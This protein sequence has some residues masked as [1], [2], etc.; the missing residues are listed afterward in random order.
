MF[1]L[2]SDA[3]SA[4]NQIGLLLMATVFILIGGAIAGY[5][6]YWRIKAQRVRGRVSGVRAKKEQKGSSFYY[7]VFEYQA[8]N[9]EM[10]EHVSS[11]G[12]N[13][14]FGKIPGTQVQ[15]MMM[16]HQPEKVRRPALILALFGLVFLLPGFWIMNVALTRFEFNYMMV[17]M[18][19]IGLGFVGFKVA[20]AVRKIPEGE[21]K[22]GW[23][24]FKEKGV[25]VT[26]SGEGSKGRLLSQDDITQAVKKQV[27]NT[28][29]GGYMC[30]LIALGLGAGSYYA[31]Q[32]MHAMLRDGVP[33]QGEVTGMKRSD[34][35]DSVT[36]SAIVRFTD[37]SGRRVKFT[38]SV[39]SSHPTLKRGDGVDVL[40]LR[41]N[42]ED[43]I[44]DRGVWNWFLS[45]ALGLGALLF[46]WGG[47]HSFALV[48]RHGGTKYRDRV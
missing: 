2:I 14:L 10:M 42:P 16:P 38:D 31:G 46:L 8:P 40:Y 47:M 11:M 4:W 15:L 36:Y 32:S 1:E 17:I 5:E 43:A 26:S 12:S 20:G 24:E 33:A 23:A 35:S 28:R 19:L 44:V 6:L 22:K 25:K 37:A 48:R 9:G 30:L 13:S 41:D 34:S 27:K 45:G 3:L 29:I 39:G 7:A 18:V 21:I